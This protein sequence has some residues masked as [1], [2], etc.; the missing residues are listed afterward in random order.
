MVLRA[1]FID[2]NSYFASVEQQLRPELRGKPVGVAPM[3]AETTCC[4]AASYEAKAFGIKTGTQVAEARRLCPDIQIVEA[5]PPLYVEFHDRL[6]AV[7]EDQIPVDKVLSIDEMVCTLDRRQSQRAVAE[8]LAVQV[9]QAIYARVGCELRSSIGIAPNLFLA[10]LASNLQKPDGLV[11]IEQHELPERLYTVDISELYGVGPRMVE[12]LNGLG[13]FSMEELYA[14][15]KATLRH[16]WNGIEGERMYARLRGEQVYTPPTKKSSLGHSH[17]LA[18][19]HR[20]PAAAFA[21]LQKLLQKAATR[22]RHDGLV[23]GRLLLYL[24]YFDHQSWRGKLR[25]DSNDDT[26]EFLRALK[27]LWRRRP[28]PAPPLLRV[29]VVLA[30]LGEKRGHTL[31]LFA[32]EDAERERLNHTMDAINDKFGRHSVYFGGAHS[33]RDSAPMRIA[34]THIPDPRLE[35]DD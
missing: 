10:K 17:V 9:K 28:D 30:G 35:G 6:V 13:I 18:P 5:R 20:T 8:A 16:A 29:G 31:S 7:V 22:L 15:S 27:L 26:R 19:D 12:R 33:A 24:D 1:F 34:F 11:V 32:E 2:F 21:V 4:I 14:A 25:L 3:L 23:A